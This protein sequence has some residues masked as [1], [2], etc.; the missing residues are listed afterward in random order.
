MDPL[1][2]MFRHLVRTIEASFPAYLS[3]PFEVGE[4]YQ[5]ILPYRHHRRELGFDTNQDY[6]MAVTQLLA[7]YGGYLIVDDAMRETLQRELASPNPDPGAFRE[8]AGSQVALAPDAVR[9][10]RGGEE[11]AARPSFVA[12]QPVGAAAGSRSESAAPAAR[13]SLG[14]VGSGTTAFSAARASS[15]SASGGGG[16]GSGGG[17]GSSGGSAG[18]MSA[19]GGSMSASGAGSSG[20]SASGASGAAGGAGSSG[21]GGGGAPGASRPSEQTSSVR[22]S[23]AAAAPRSA[24]PATPTGTVR[25]PTPITVA[26]GQ[27][28]RY[29][30]GVLPSG[31]RI[32]FCPHCGQDLTTVNCQA[33]GTELELGW[34]FCTT[35]GRPVASANG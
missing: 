10:V 30:G 2:R 29:C 17:V 4:L 3:R 23:S 22:P 16:A 1:E 31:R 11:P 14:A 27:A 24:T 25:Q 34:K 21:M 9:R 6:E 26:A 5:T 28:C 8:F 35:C 33:C 12:P 7:G 15:A 32:V 19:G 20:M 18:G 13:S